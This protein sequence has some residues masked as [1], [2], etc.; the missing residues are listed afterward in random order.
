LKESLWKNQMRVDI[1][2]PSGAEFKGTLEVNAN[3]VS[4]TIPAGT[5]SQ[6]VYLSSVPTGSYTMNLLDSSKASAVVSFGE[7]QEFSQF[8][9]SAGVQDN[10]IE[11]HSENGV[12]TSSKAQTSLTSD[13]PSSFALLLPYAFTKAPKSYE[14]VYSSTV[15]TI[16]YGVRA[17]RFWMKGDGKATALYSRIIDSS[18]QIF[19][20]YSMGNT[21]NTGWRL[22]ELPLDDFYPDQ[23]NYFNS[24]ADGVLHFPIRWDSLVIVNS[25]PGGNVS[26]SVQISRP[27]YI[28]NG[29]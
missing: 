19:Q 27:I 2:N 1:L 10:F 14:Q 9:N 25:P 7:M 4:V 22:I 21:G 11:R 17:A 26:G 18:G 20:F 29:F 5:L 23:E 8:L 16:P 12:T 28:S 6:T 3:A 15:Q 13:G 24:P